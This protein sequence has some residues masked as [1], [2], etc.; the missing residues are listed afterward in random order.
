M[1]SRI[2][3]GS[4]SGRHIIVR[5]Q[6]PLMAKEWRKEREEEWIER[7]SGIIAQLLRALRF[8]GPFKNPNC[9]GDSS[10]LLANDTVVKFV[11]SDKPEFNQHWRTLFKKK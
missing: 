11:E 5:W 2:E 7:F 1:P 8:A 10:I 4:D 3:N 9:T 6:F